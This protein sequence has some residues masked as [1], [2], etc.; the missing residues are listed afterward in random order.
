[1]TLAPAAPGWETAPGRAAVRS[2]GGGGRRH[3]ALSSHLIESAQYHC[4]RVRGWPG[5][6]ARRAARGSIV[7]YILCCIA[8]TQRA[9]QN[10]YCHLPVPQSCPC[11]LCNISSYSWVT[12]GEG[13]PP[14]PTE[15]ITGVG[16]LSSRVQRGKHA[17]LWPRTT[18]C[19]VRWIRLATAISGSLLYKMPGH[20]PDFPG[21][22]SFPEQR[23]SFQ[24]SADSPEPLSD[25][26]A[27]K[28]GE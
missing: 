12:S 28:R 9:A 3:C 20:S 21:S 27:N 16:C 19:W 13:A 15:K 4:P 25:S 6:L 22:P 23:P 26:R 10:S 11:H 18:S 7:R 24:D 14:P 2:A 17:Q 8:D 1:M 5:K